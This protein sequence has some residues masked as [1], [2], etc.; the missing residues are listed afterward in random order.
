MKFN[1]N[2]KVKVRLTD[3]GRTIHRKDFDQLGMKSLNYA[4]PEEDSRG[5]SEWQLWELMRLFGPHLYN[6]CCVPF[7][8]EIKI[9]KRV[10]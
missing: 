1:I 10:S 6:G 5:W 7:E 3:I 9:P 4:P 2:H 8:T